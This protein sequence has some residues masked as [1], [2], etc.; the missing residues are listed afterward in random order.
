MTCLDSPVSCQE[1]HIVTYHGTEL[2]DMRI[3]YQFNRVELSG[4]FDIRLN[5]EWLILQSQVR[6]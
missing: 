6:W 2:V 4:D 5:A 3:L 1:S